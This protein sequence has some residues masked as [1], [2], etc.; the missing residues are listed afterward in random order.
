M[1]ARE[2]EYKQY[3]VDHINEVQ[4]QY[5]KYKPLFEKLF[6]EVFEYTELSELMEYTIQI[7]DQSKF[8]KEEFQLYCD[9][10]FPDPVKGKISGTEFNGAWLHHIHCNPHHPQHWLYYDEDTKKVTAYDIPD[11]NLIDLLCDWLAMSVYKKDTIWAYWEASGKNKQYSLN[12]RTKLKWAIREIKQYT[13]ENT[14][15]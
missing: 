10:F 15:L 3:I 8:S 13:E 6:P 4:R 7:H 9:W 12:T 14:I 11:V 1:S 5:A 2:L